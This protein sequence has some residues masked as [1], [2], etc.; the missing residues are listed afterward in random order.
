MEKTGLNYIDLVY[1]VLENWYVTFAE[2]TPKLIVGIL[3]FTFFLSQVNISAIA[4]KFFINSSQK[5]KKKV[6]W[7]L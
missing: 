2:L 1:K 7:L 4:V 6:H 5:A 3:V